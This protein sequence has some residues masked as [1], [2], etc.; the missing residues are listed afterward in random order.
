M[1]QVRHV[2]SDTAP[3]ESAVEEV[4]GGDI[5]S[6]FASDLVHLKGA[7][8]RICFP[9]DILFDALDLLIATTDIFKRYVTENSGTVLHMREFVHKS[10]G[11]LEVT[12]HSENICQNQTDLF[13]PSCTFGRSHSLGLVLGF[14]I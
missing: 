12:P 11:R 6:D 3:H 7:S 8:H 9:V 5:C 13:K 1:E 4:V 2:H 14:R 10:I